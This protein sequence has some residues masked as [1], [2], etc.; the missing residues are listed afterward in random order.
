MNINIS[1]LH[2]K[3]ANH[4]ID[5]NSLEPLSDFKALQM[6]CSQGLGHP[7]VRIEESLF[8]ADLI[9]FKSGERVKL[10]KHKG[11]HILLVLSGIGRLVIESEFLKLEPGIIYA[12]PSQAR[13][14]IESEEDLYLLSIGNNHFPVD[15]PKRLEPVE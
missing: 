5:D 8:G 2:A 4:N 9:K 3:F 1:E 14:S 10:H 6:H 11:D 12:V 7:L 15:S 13:H